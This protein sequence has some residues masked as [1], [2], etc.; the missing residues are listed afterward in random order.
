MSPLSAGDNGVTAWLRGIEYFLSPVVVFTSLI[1]LFINRLLFRAGPEIL[2]HVMSP[3]L[4]LLALIGRIAI[5]L[6]QLLLFVVL[7][8]AGVL[9][10]EEEHFRFL[11]MLLVAIVAGSALL[12]APLAADQAWAISALLIIFV[13]FSVLGLACLRIV[14]NRELPTKQRLTLAGFLSCLV[15]S[16]IF[17][18]YYRMYLLVGAAGLASLS[19]PVEAYQAGIYLIMAT[20]IAAFAYALAAPSPGF[21][22][23][24]RNFAKAAILPTLLV[25]PT[26]YGVMTSFFAAQILAML[27]AMSTDFVLSH[28]LLRALVIFS[29]FFL[30]AVLVLV[31]KGHYSADRMLQQEGMGLILIMS[32]TFLFNYPYYLML[33]TAGVFLLCYPLSRTD[34]SD[35]RAPRTFSESTLGNR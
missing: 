16:F 2:R 24:Y 4:F 18:L 35:N 17:P 31:L 6:E 9:L 27:L 22:L 14:R 28:D 19:F 33:G 20:T 10:L 21:T 30:T 1:D 12:Y 32:T 11:G 13:G 7:A 34:Y 5:T 23:G 3:N 26:L 29:W 25:V 15:L 8:A